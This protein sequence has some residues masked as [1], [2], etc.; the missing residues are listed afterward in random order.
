MS[1]SDFITDF[2]CK[3]FTIYSFIWFYFT[4]EE[5]LIFFFLKCI[6]LL[7]KL[8]KTE[9]IGKELSNK[10]RFKNKTSNFPVVLS[11]SLSSV[12]KYHWIKMASMS[13]GNKFKSI[14]IIDVWLSGID[15]FFQLK[16]ACTI[17]GYMKLCF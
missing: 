15:I 10:I 4:W 5:M 7:L 2:Q 14:E 6:L 3:L 11:I 8:Q 9:S 12:S 17:I 16:R 1:K 13:R